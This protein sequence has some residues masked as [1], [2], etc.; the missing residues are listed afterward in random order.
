MELFFS[1]VANVVGMFAVNYDK[2]TRHSNNDDCR[3]FIIVA[4]K[5]LEDF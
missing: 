3:T 4:M 1:Q 5:I 2:N